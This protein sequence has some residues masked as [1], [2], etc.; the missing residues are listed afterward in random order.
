MSKRDELKNKK[1]AVLMGGLSAER[2][3]SLRTGQA[4]LQALQANDCNAVAVD[5]GRD[6]P[7]QLRDVEAELAFICLHGRF[8]EDGTVQGL[9]EMMQIPYTGSGVMASSM[10][11]DKVIT[12][13]SQLY[14]IILI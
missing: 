11:I 12:K 10:A 2:D 14:Q 7:I 5:A 9:L 1:I 6:L 3:I 4:V 13:R 8:G